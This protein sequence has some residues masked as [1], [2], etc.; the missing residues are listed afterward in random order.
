MV[1]GRGLDQPRLARACGALHS[2]GS[3]LRRPNYREVVSL[4]ILK[5]SNAGGHVDSVLHSCFADD[6]DVRGEVVLYRS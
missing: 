2:R 3:T 4:L 6:G 5:A 1:R